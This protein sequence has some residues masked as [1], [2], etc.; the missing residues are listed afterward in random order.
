MWFKMTLTVA[1]LLF[2]I[3]LTHRVDAWFLR[4]VGTGDRSIPVSRRFGSGLKGL[5]RVLF[6]A[7][8]F[9]L[10]GSVLL[11]V[12]LQGRI[13]R[14]ERDRLA[15]VMHFGLFLGFLLLLLV[16]ALGSTLWVTLDPG[17]QPTLDP[18]LFLR[19][20]GGVLLL[21]GLVLALFRR[22]KHR[23]TGSGPR[24]RMSGPSHCWP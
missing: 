4:T 1:L 14:D 13:L 6:S 19:N 22:V 9:P 11:D 10:L 21:T 7:R 18:Y 2:L 20:L 15:W 16:H 17:Y 23:G 8:I 12:L 24:R 3:G 5:L